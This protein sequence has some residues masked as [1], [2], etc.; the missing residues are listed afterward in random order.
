MSFLNFDEYDKC[1]NNTQFNLIYTNVLTGPQNIG[2]TGLLNW[3]ELSL[4]LGRVVLVQD[5]IGPS[6]K[7]YRRN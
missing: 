1:L 5:F 3:A 7:E 6:S 4:E 2:P